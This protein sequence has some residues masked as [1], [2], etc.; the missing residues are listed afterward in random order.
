M[1][2]RT[3]L[4]VLKAD[5]EPGMNRVSDVGIL[6]V[7]QKTHL[8]KKQ[9]KISFLEFIKAGRKSGFFFLHQRHQNLPD[10]C[11]LCPGLHFSSATLHPI[12][13]QLHIANP[14]EVSLPNAELYLSFF[15]T[16]F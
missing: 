12:I 13:C 3:L 14:K 15:F 2:F 9:V 7:K 10:L 4:L 1:G 11:S 16:P 6:N 8:Y 5:R